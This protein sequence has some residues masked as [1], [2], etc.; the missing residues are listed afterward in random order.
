MGPKNPK[1]LLDSQF[2]WTG[3][4]GDLFKYMKSCD[5]F[6]RTSPVPTY[7][8]DIYR[9]FTRLFD[10]FSIYFAGPY[11]TTTDGTGYI[12]FFVERLKSWRNAKSKDATDSQG[13][14]V[15]R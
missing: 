13:I 4:H 10:V 8:T 15:F 1:T 6:Q 11:P 3:V 7:R 9:P 5:A 14:K 12:L 2:W